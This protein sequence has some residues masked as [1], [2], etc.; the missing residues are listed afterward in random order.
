MLTS[1]GV[2]ELVELAGSDIKENAQYF[3]HKID[4]LVMLKEVIPLYCENQ[5]NPT[6]MLLR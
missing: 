3:H 1:L 6:D 5:M 2:H 4:R